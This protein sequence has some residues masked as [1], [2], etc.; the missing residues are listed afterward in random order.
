MENEE[1]RIQHQVDAEMKFQKDADLL[2]QRSAGACQ[3]EALIK[4]R[5]YIVYSISG[6]THEGACLVFAQSVKEARKLGFSVT[7]DWF[8][9]DWIDTGAEWLK[10]ERYTHLFRTEANQEKLKNGIAHVIESP[11]SC[12]RCE[13]WG[14]EIKDEICEDCKEVEEDEKERELEHAA[15]GLDSTRDA[16]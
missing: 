10:G 9:S 2:N 5:A 8:D 12:A 14:S 1:Q 7:S 16:V 3:I 13:L 6:G 11:K 15:F 4:L